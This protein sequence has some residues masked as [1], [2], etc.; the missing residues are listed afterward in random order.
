MAL[1][2]LTDAEV[3][4]EARDIEAHRPT[5]TEQVGQANSHPGVNL[6][7]RPLNFAFL[8]VFLIRSRSD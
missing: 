5:L 3:E 4:P 2:G 7:V 1:A 8:C 6:I